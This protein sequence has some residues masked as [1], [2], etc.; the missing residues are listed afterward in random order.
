MNVNKYEESDQ[1]LTPAYQAKKTAVRR[2]R[3]ELREIES[4]DNVCVPT[5]MPRMMLFGAFEVLV[6]PKSL[7]IV[8]TGGGLQVRNIW[9]DG[10]KHTPPEELFDSFGGESIGRWEGD[11]L[12]VDTVGIRPTNQVLY[13]IVAPKLAVVERIRKT[14][15]DTLEIVTTVSDPEVFTQPWVYTTNYKRTFEKVADEWSYCVAAFYRGVE[16]DGSAGFD[17]TPPPDQS[18]LS[19]AAK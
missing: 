5:G 15:R 10:R 6:R 13:G 9:L 11:T 2:N 17:L 1:P 8:G 4:S 18:E 3:A 12:V 14:G 19:T 16:K 7:G